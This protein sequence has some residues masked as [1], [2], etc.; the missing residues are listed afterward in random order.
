[1][2]SV[3]IPAK[4]T[5]VSVKVYVPH[6]NI[7]K[8]WGGGAGNRGTDYKEPIIPSETDASSYRSN[9]HENSQKPFTLC[10]SLDVSEE[11]TMSIPQSFCLP[12]DLP[13]PFKPRRP[14]SGIS[15]ASK[16]GTC[17]GTTRESQGFHNHHNI[18]SISNILLETRSQR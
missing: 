4:L 11:N 5:N 17:H 10:P 14:R 12:L 13:I 7:S 9:C 16:C 3:E 15:N 2:G 8:Q 6:K 18:N 1:L